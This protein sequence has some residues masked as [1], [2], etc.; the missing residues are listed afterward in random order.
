MKH[1]QLIL[2]IV[3]IISAI[4][5][6]SYSYNHESLDLKFLLDSNTVVTTTQPPTEIQTLWA[7]Y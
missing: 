2:S 6:F 7:Q 1:T 3:L 4:A 5:C